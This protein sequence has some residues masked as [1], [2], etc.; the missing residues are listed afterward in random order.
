MTLLGLSIVQQAGDSADTF[1]SANALISA[2]PGLS[3]S[4]R[5]LRWLSGT[6]RI[7]N[8]CP[9]ASQASLINPAKTRYG[10]ASVL[11]SNGLFSYMVNGVTS[12]YWTNE[13]STPIGTSVDALPS[14]ATALGYL[15]SSLQ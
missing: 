4:K 3:F 14:A 7:R 1:W 11:L 10:F 5:P 15:D 2:V 12:P 8:A 9:A 6:R 13:F